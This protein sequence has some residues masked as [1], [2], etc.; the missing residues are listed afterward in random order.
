M[1]ALT[2]RQPWAWLVVHGGKR[3]ENRRWRTSHRGDFLIHAGKGM[4]R[5]EYDDAGCMLSDVATHD[6][7]LPAYEKIERG[8]I[9]GVA[10]L[11]D[12]V[13]PRHEFCRCP[14]GAP[15]HYPAG[16]EWRWHMR[17]QFGFI[18]TEVRPLPFRP[19]KGEL[20]FFETG[21]GLDDVE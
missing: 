20:G 16:I 10:R 8:G 6:V 18:L 2:L 14:G 17:E 15:S 19:L 5:G 3:V 11:V 7:R 1:K 21:L 13:P 4:T 9:V 12:V